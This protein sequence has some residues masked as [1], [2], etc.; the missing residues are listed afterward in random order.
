M[1]IV[2]EELLDEFRSRP[3][4]WCGSGHRSDPHHIFTRGMDGGSRLDIRI[5]LISLCRHCHIQV[6]YGNL[7]RIHLLKEVSIREGKPLEFIVGEIQRIRRLPKD[8]KAGGARESQTD[9]DNQRGGL[10]PQK[11]GQDDIT[12]NL[13]ND[14]GGWIRFI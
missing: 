12:S 7:D 2:D 5:N 3:C 4:E 10:L 8:A 13:E 14:Q 9:T 1:R 11:S 6:H